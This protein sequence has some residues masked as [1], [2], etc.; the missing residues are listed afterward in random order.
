MKQYVKNY[1]MVGAIDTPSSQRANGDSAS[2]K[3]LI[4][5]ALEDNDQPAAVLDIG[6][7][8]GTL[9][10]LI[11]T[12]AA[13][14]HWHV[15]GIDGFEPNC[16]NVQLFEKSIYRNV[17]CSLAQN[18]SSDLL[19]RYNLIC[20]LDVIEHLD[21]ESA[22][23]LLR[24]LLTSMDDKAALFISTPLWF[25][26]QQNVQDGDLEE[27]LIGVPASSMMALLPTHYAVNHPLVGGFIFRKKSLDYI[28]FFQPTSDKSFSFEHGIN[29]ARAVGMRL[30]A[31]ICVTTGL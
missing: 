4:F 27:H 10:A 18:L 6:F 16:K 11:R 17:W 14:A 9:G 8:A 20:L 28:S 13:T 19:G 25:Y 21:A 31:D 30:E 29:V 1:Q 3:G 7:G 22:K 12:N 23:W 2:P 5:H 26:P 15:D 24:Y